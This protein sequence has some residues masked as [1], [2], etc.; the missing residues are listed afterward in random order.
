MIL[1]CHLLVGAAIAAKIQ[2]LPLAII[3]AFL[4]HYVLD[5]IPHWEYSVNNILSRQWRKSKFDFLK[6]AL[7]FG[8]GILLIFIF[9]K[10][11]G[12]ILA[13][14]FL[15]VL[16]DGFTLLNLI[17]PNRLLKIHDKFHREYFLRS[18]KSPSKSTRLDFSRSLENKILFLFGIFSQIL[19]SILAI[20]LLIF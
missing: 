8:F 20:F 7:D 18:L 12:I 10:T 5:F 14:A 16:P 2:I 9:S 11:S 13:G 17:L 19:I 4:S 3:L 15:A 6:V 1:F